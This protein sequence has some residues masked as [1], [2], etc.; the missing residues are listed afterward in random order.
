MQQ[1]CDNW[2]GFFVAHL[3][4]NRAVAINFINITRFEVQVV[5]FQIQRTLKNKPKQLNKIDFFVLELLIY[6]ACV[7]ILIQFIVL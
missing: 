7:S 2:V 1:T 3:D 6:I 5:E 4:F